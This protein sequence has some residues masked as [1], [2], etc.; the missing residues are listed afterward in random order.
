MRRHGAGEVRRRLSAEFACWR[1]RRQACWLPC[2]DD[3]YDDFPVIR[4]YVQER[5]RWMLES[6]RPDDG[7]IN[8][9]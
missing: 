9:K 8:G 2:P 4:E 7:I 5:L 1:R 6:M 3:L